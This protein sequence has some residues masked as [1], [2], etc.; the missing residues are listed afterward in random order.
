MWVPVMHVGIVRVSMDQRRVNVRVYVRFGSV[1]GK[2]EGMLMV[3][4]L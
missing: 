4:V 2:I 3:L 1:P